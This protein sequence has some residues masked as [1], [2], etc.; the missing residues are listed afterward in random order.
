[1]TN[2]KE[3]RIMSTTY[4]TCAIC[5]R[6]GRIAED[7]TDPSDRELAMDSRG[8]AAANEYVCGRCLTDAED[9]AA[10]IRAERAS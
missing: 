5:D 4:A 8:V 2:A 1:M 10:R 9:R 3:H 6:R 7:E